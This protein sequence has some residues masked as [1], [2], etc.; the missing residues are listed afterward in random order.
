MVP[1]FAVACT[2]SSKRSNLPIYSPAAAVATD[3]KFSNALLKSGTVF[4][5]LTVTGISDGDAILSF[6]GV[7]SHKPSWL[8]AHE[9]RHN[10]YKEIPSNTFL[11]SI[12]GVLRRFF[13]FL[14]P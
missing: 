8:Q 10:L 7:S 5:L 4:V 13:C 11:E 12:R 6:Q 3:L 2:G 1:L 9:D 14:V